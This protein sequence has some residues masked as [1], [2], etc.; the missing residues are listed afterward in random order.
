MSTLVSIV[1]VIIDIYIGCLIAS[2]I[3]SWL[4][5]FNILNIQNPIVFK[6]LGL[7][8]RITDPP[9]R[10]IRKIIPS[11]AGID[12]SPVILIFA[13]VILWDLIRR[14]LLGI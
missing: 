11:L 4:V 1:D 9:L 5:S 6:V 14:S 3:V 13:I 10:P 12:F 8:W 2:A 7:L